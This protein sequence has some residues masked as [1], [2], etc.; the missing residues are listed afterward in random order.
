MAQPNPSTGLVLTGKHLLLLVVFVVLATNSL[1]RDA[2]TFDETSHIAAGASYVATG[3][4]RLNPE[5]PP[6]V[7]WLAGGAIA[8]W[9]DR[10]V[11]ENAGWMSAPSTK[12]AWR[13]ADQWTFG[14][15]FLNGPAAEQPRKDPLEVL[16]PA[17]LAMVLFG[18]IGAL[19][20][21]AW[22]TQ[23]WGQTGGLLSLLLYVLSPT[24]LAHTRLVTTD[25]AAAVAVLAT[26]FAF[27]QF[28]RRPSI[29]G[30][31]WV[32][33]ALGCALLI[34]FSALILPAVL[35]V[36]WLIWVIIGGRDQP[37]IAPNRSTRFR[38]GLAGLLGA[39]LLAWAIVWAGYGLRYDASPDPNFTVPWHQAGELSGPRGQL[40]AIARD[41]KLLPEAYLFGVAFVSGNAD[42][43]LA[44]LDGERRVTG[45]ARYFPEVFVLKTPPALL[46]LLLLLLVL[47]LR[48]GRP[49]SLDTWFIAVPMAAYGLLLAS[50][51]LNI[52]HRHLAPLYPLLMISAGAA[53]PL[54]SG[55]IAWQRFAVIGLVLGFG[56]SSM[57]ASPR[58]LSYF[59]V[60]GGGAK[61][62]WHH[63]VDSNIDWGQDLS[64]LPKWMADN[65]AGEIYLVYFGTADP[66][67]YGIPYL[68]VFQHFD[69]RPDQRPVPFV[70]GKLLAVSV[71]LLQGLYLK[72]GYAFAHAAHRA[73]LA[74]QADFSAWSQ[75]KE[76]QLADGEEITPLPEWLVSQGKLSDQQRQALQ[77]PLLS[78]LL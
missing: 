37:G 46:V 9:S 19:L 36:L 13:R 62:G 77:A 34:K 17:R 23:I 69:P 63:L 72:D 21:T 3:D 24:I 71:T 33:L 65:N 20:V 64:R 55:A 73:G 7:K 12:R 30:A 42:R 41:A 52:G 60:L 10:S 18:L 26:A 78:T 15:D 44:F 45:W 66:A 58:Y 11:T 51:H 57:A 27:R 35:V 39:G 59:S 29:R 67:A 43:R 5:H 74:N 54:L 22:S 48:Q 31:L 68:K 25:L 2:A 40:L 70:S 8:A 76:R 4:F 50:S 47:R 32:G 75:M 1:V 38:Q 56:I 14:F 28:V 61:G 49:P 16:L 53:G 6:L